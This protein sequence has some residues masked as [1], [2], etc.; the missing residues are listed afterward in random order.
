MTYT[1]FVTVLLGRKVD[2]TAPY[3]YLALPRPP[4]A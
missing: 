2:V 3:R 1:V 4:P